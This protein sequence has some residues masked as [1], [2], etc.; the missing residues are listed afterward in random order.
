MSTS[1]IPEKV[2]IRLWGQAAGRCQY[3]GCNKPLWLD[4]LTKEEFNVTYIAHIIADKP[5]GPRGD[6]ELSEKYKDDISNLM[7]MCDEHHRFIDKEDEAGHPVERLRVMKRKHEDRIEMLTSLM[8]DKQSHIILYGANIG[9]H[10]APLS[11]KK[12]YQAMLPRWY[13]AEKPA[14]ELSW[15]N[16]FFQDHEE[17]YW[18][19]E[20]ENLHRQFAGRVK[21]KMSA[22]EVEHFSI[23]ALAPQPLLMELGR[24]LSDIPAAEVYQLHREPPNW[25]W[26]ENPEDFD[27]ILQEPTV[28]HKAVALNLSLSATIDNTRVTTVLGDNISIWTLTIE[29]PHN[30]FLQSRGQ[31]G[32]FR[33]IFRQLLNRIKA[34]HGQDALLHLFPAAPVAI[35]VE[36]GRVWMP[37]ADLSIR[38]YDQNWKTGGFSETFDISNT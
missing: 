35:A 36:I 8:E 7:L 38:I 28:H 26:Q 37:K 14:I 31:L 6:P 9:Q 23:F 2:K 4:L 25:I 24:L 22:G 16:S 19:I 1:Y 27:F 12:A 34:I 33:Q 15:K 3:E 20:R 13:P 17:T 21:P 30:D 11:F 5:D 18:A 29:K 10:G 32:L